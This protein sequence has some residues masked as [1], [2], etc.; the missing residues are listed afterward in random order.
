MGPRPAH[1]AH[2]IWLQGKDNVPDHILELHAT[3]LTHHPHWNIQW[4]DDAR[5][6]D[7]GLVNFDLYDRAAEYVPDHSVYQ[8]QADVAR[9]EILHR[10][11]GAYLDL[12]YRWQAPIDPMLVGKSVVTGWEIDGKYAANGFIFSRSPK[13]TLLT[14]YRDTLPSWI[15][16]QEK[17]AGRR[18]ALGA[19]RLTG[20]HPWSKVLHDNI[21][22]PDLLVMPSRILTPIA[23]NQ[24][25]SAD[26]ANY[27][28]S[29]AI[30]QWQ[31]GRGMK[32][33]GPWKTW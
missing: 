30:H 28:D 1:T 15:A 14:Q 29:V 9:I 26:E 22:R 32:V 12:D 5:I 7:L 27:T 4:W 33:G 8:M 18:R 17:G 24:W 10:H 3:F 21:D 20:P 23:W 13:H 19:N 25:Q 2:L 6:R 31:H 16:E 11:G